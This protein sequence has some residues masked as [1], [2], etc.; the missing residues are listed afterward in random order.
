[1]RVWLVVLW[2]GCVTMAGS[3]QASVR[4]DD[5]SETPY[6]QLAASSLYDSVGRISFS[7]GQSSYLASGVLISPDWVLTAGHVVGGNDYLGGGIE[8]L[9]F[10]L[11][12][13]NSVLSFA[14]SAW[15]AHPGWTY[16]QGD[17]AAGYDLG[18]IHLQSSVSTIQAA[19]LYLSETLQIQAGTMV[20][21]GATGTGITGA[22]A[23]T[24]GT[25]RAGQNMIEVQGD[26]ETISSSLLFVDFDQPGTD[27]NNV[28]GGDLPLPL[29][30][31]IGP[32]DSGG[33]LFVTQNQQTFLVGIASFTWGI[34]D[35][36]ADSTYGDVAAFTSTTSQLTWIH[37]MTGVPI[38]EPSTGALLWVGVVGLC[39]LRR[40][41]RSGL[42]YRI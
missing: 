27:A 16:T 34:L 25:K 6:L 1:M 2:V 11:T 42:G 10:S 28:F 13:E 19:S 23:G 32:G 40:K 18:L 17:I 35:G 7:V 14:A 36:V 12:A 22:Q 5:V 33:G 21:Y 26:G 37:A 41:K 15:Y 39:W 24:A 8:N 20:G 3:V 9:T 31:L 4:R 38:P 30:S 29:E